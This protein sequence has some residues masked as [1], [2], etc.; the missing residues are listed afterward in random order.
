MSFGDE[1][2]PYAG[3]LSKTQESFLLIFILLNATSTAVESL[4]LRVDSFYDILNRLTPNL[5][6]IHRSHSF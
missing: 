4:Y 1:P 2:E 6:P 3:N 5:N